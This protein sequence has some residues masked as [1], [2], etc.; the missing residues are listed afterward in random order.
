[1]KSSLYTA[2]LLS[3]LLLGACGAEDP[4]FVT[5]SLGRYMVEVEEGQGSSVGPQEYTYSVEESSSEPLSSADALDLDDLLSSD[6]GNTSSSPDEAVAGGSEAGSKG[7]GQGKEKGNG[8]KASGDAVPSTSTPD[9]GGSQSGGSNIAKN[10]G[11][12]ADDGSTGGGS[13]D[14]SAPES[15]ADK[16]LAKACA[17]HFRGIGSKIKVLSADRPNASVT[18]SPDTVIA[19]HL[20]GNNDRIELNLG[21]SEGIAGLCL[22][23]NGSESQAIVN[24]A[25]GFQKLVYVGRG[26]MS[27]TQLSMLDGAGIG[28]MN[29]ELS[30]NQP[31]LEIRGVAEGGCSAAKVKGNAAS[32][33]CK[34]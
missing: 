25:S 33:I 13:S 16:A 2:S 34:P 31:K 10:G 8:K 15:D 7:K 29:I 14:P 4:S 18:I 30:G 5:Q 21:A 24:S 23:L 3:T 28:A 9:D 6:E 12:T 11:G 20:R 32:L 17:P 19:F 1:M 26:N 22:I 27:K